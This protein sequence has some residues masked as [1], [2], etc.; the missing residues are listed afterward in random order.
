[1]I[2]IVLRRRAAPA[3]LFAG[4]TLLAAPAFAGDRPATPEGAQN[5]QAFFDR[6]LPAPPPADRPWSP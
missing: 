6:F 5:L 2:A 1:M 3:A 4:A